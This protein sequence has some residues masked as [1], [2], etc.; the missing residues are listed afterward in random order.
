M[1]LVLQDTY[2]TV[3]AG[4]Q[5]ALALYGFATYYYEKNN[6]R[7]GASFTELNIL[8]FFI[9]GFFGFN[10]LVYAGN[11]FY[12]LKGGLLH[13]IFAYSQIPSTVAS[14][15]A[16]AAV[17]YIYFED[18]FMSPEMWYLIGAG[19]GLPLLEIAVVVFTYNSV[20]LKYRFYHLNFA[21]CFDRSG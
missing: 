16:L 14:F 13:R 18:L 12:D 7:K 17:I 1:Q 9:M 15:I 10:S 19:V 2:N 11:Y 20:Q 4:S 6:P 8:T 5:L 3:Y 21:K